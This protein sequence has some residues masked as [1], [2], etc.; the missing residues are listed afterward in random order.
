MTGIR[1][2][3]PDPLDVFDGSTFLRNAVLFTRA[4]RSAGVVT[5]LGGGLD[6][7]RALTLVDIGDRTQVHAAGSAVFCRRRPDLDTYDAV[8]DQFWRR[9]TAR[10]APTGLEVGAPRPPRPPKDREAGLETVPGR[11]RP[12][13]PRGRPE[14]AEPGAG[15]DHQ[16]ADAG[17][18][19]SPRAFSPGEAFHHRDFD[20]MTNTELRDAERL[21]DL[22]R[23]H[24]E[25]RLTRRYELHPHG[26]RLAPR[27]MY[28]RNLG[29]G[30]D[31]VDWVWRRRLRRPRSIVVLCDVSGSMER[32]ARILLRFVQ[33]LTRAS[34]VRT[35]SF[36][37][38]TRLTRISHELRGRD[39]DLAIR[40][41][42]EAVSD[43]SGGTRIGDS[44][45][46]FNLRWARRV[47]RTSGVVIVVSDGWDRGDPE[48]V[49]T[50]TA[51]L[52]RNCH[53]L[54]WLNPLAGAEGYQPIAA[55]MAAAYPS[56]DDFLPIQSIASL[57]RLGAILGGMGLGSAGRPPRTGTPRVH[58]A[59]GS[60]PTSTRSVRSMLPRVAAPPG[61]AGT[62]PG[63]AA[64]A[65]PLGDRTAKG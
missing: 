21:I 8:F 53:R 4:L 29:A 43:W 40:R 27:A 58:H 46:A 11:D 17:W 12:G 32:H 3:V 64:L 54:I 13:P 61:S 14:Q 65:R 35:E 55:G 56:I 1:A 57:E 50:E 52:Q 39:P 15:D 62:P 34:G 38:G 7:A 36:V 44:L 25:S 2:P 45:R 16:E 5:D 51:R 24:L 30:G 19:V 26:K 49:R 60:G 33:A 28:R 42:S 48:L 41:V 10:I 22:L 63:D 18:V 20:R 6:F 59:E 47:L 23:P 37:F 9:H 31:L